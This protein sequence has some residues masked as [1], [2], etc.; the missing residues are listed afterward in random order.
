MIIVTATVN[1]KHIKVRQ[2]FTMLAKYTWGQDFSAVPLPTNYL[3]ASA[4]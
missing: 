4:I 1:A 2:G 3:A